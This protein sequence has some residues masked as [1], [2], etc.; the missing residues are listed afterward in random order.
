MICKNNPENFKGG[1]INSFL[2]VWEELFKDEWV[3]SHVEGVKVN[4]DEN[5]FIPEKKEINFPPSIKMAIYK[6]VQTLLEK[7]VITLVKDTEGQIISNVFV[8]EKK[9]GAFRVILNLKNFNK[10]LDK[11]HFKMESL[12]NAINL[13]TQ[14]CFFASIDLKDA[15]F[16]VNIHPDSR[17]YFRF[18]FLGELYEFKGL[19]QG[20]KDS[21]R[22]FTK[23]TRPILGLLRKKGHSLVG[24]ID[25][26][27]IKANTKEQ[28]VKSVVETGRNF[29]DLGFTV[30]PKKSVLSPK[31][32]IEFLGFVLNSV[33]MQVSVSDEKAEDVKSKISEFLLQEVRT[34]RDF[35][36]IIG[37]LVALNPGVWIG[38]LFWRRLEIEKS[39]WLKAYKGNFD[40]EFPLSETAK[41]DLNWWLN[42]V[43]KYPVE[44]VKAS[45]SLT[46]TTDASLDG[47]GAVRGEISTGGHWTMEE[48]SCHINVLELKA[49]LF[50][51]KALCK[52]EK[53]ITVRVQTDNSTTKACINRIGSAREAC[54]SV[55]R[56]LWLWCLER[57]IML[58]AVHLPGVENVEADS[59]SRKSRGIE[60]MLDKEIFS[61]LEKILGPFELDLFASRISHQLDRYVS[62]L[63]DP[64][65][66]GIDAFTLDWDIKGIYCFPPFCLISLVL[67]RLV[68]QK[69][70]MTLIAP[71]WPQQVW[72]P[73]LLEKLIEV[74]VILP[75]RERLVT[76]PVTNRAMNNVTLRL[77][78]CTISGDSLKQKV[79]REKLGIFSAQHGERTQ[80]R[81]IMY[82]LGNGQYSVTF[83]DSMWWIL[84]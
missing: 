48:K 33:K 42:N 80:R 26:F 56:L 81:L 6:E 23:L 32:Q 29:D 40:R 65:A 51:I 44:V 18:R 71:M 53:S 54:N 41:E 69:A 76:N 25:D 59:E 9:D 60:W 47:W 83:K 3:L 31:Q 12:R 36:V 22:I 63:P 82:T 70:T 55:T 28:C 67:S 34:I 30:H 50:G 17:K 10:C 57:N 15:Y 79:F 62:W 58:E 66:W 35:A 13:M 39:M 68:Q 72:Y 77:M 38:P 37:I 8:R 19:P 52:D 74:P 16:S 7:E 14:D 61:E 1:K 11:I 4:F 46:L 49:V 75:C 43:Q 84:M 73:Q 24:Y 27:M 21:P 2:H 45:P 5:N 64:G 78:A 20:Y